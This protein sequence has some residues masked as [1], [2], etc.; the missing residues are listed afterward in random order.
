MRGNRMRQSGDERL[1][2]ISTSLGPTWPHLAPLGPTRTHSDPGAKSLG[3]TRP[4]LAP[5]PSH[6]VPLGPRAESL[7]PTWPQ[8]R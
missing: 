4:H 3:L 2:M 6:L 7:G 1:Q 8:G 5:G